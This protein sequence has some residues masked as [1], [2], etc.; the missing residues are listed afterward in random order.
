LATDEQSLTGTSRRD[1]EPQASA[2]IPRQLIR[3]ELDISG[4]EPFNVLDGREEDGLLAA[5]QGR[6]PVT[7]RRRPGVAEPP[8]VLSTPHHEW[9]P[10]LWQPRRK[11]LPRF[12]RNGVARNCLLLPHEP[13]SRS[14]HDERTGA[15][16]A[17]KYATAWLW[18]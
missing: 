13:L 15:Y 12:G 17:D 5:N 8:S 6:D 9:E 4:I 3:N 2:Q 14:S 16:Q 10:A 1:V 11:C 18:V 7:S